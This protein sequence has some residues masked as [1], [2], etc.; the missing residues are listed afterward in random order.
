MEYFVGLRSRVAAGASVVPLVLAGLS[1]S[2][3]SLTTAY[4]AG[5]SGGQA[6]YVGTTAP[7][8]SSGSGSAGGIS[9]ATAARDVGHPSSVHEGA[10]TFPSPSGTSVS[11]SPGGATT[12]AGLTHADQRLAGTGPYT[13]TQFSLEPPDQGLCVGNGKVLETIN[14]AFT[15]YSTSGVKLTAT[16]ALNQFFMR[17]PALIRPSLVRGDFIS[18]P[19]CYYDPVGNRW[20]QTVTEVDAPGSILLPLPTH[21][22]IAVSTS[23]DPTGTWN[24]FSITATD[25]GTNG[26]PSHAGCP[27]LADQ[28]LLGAN[29]DGVYISTNE[30]ELTS[31]LFHFNGAQIYALGR[32]SLEAASGGGSVSFAH[33][34]LG[35]V[36]TGD[37]NLPFWGSV[38]PSTSPRPQGGTEL[39]MSASPEDQFQNNALVDNRIAVWS[40]TGTQTLDS[41][42]PSLKVAHR[43]LRTE[44]YGSD[45]VGGFAATQKSGPTPLRDALGDKDA[46]NLLNANDSRMNQ[47][48][49]ANGKLYGGVNTVVTA[50]GQPNRVGI[51]YFVVEAGG[52]SEDRGDGA[53]RAQLARQGYLAVNGE[54]VMFPSIGVNAEGQGAMVFSLSGPDFYPSAAYVRFD[55]G[56]AHGPIHITAAGVLPDDG[57]TGYAAFGGNGIARWGDYSAALADRDGSIWMATEWIPGT[58]RTVNANW[59]TSISHLSNG[60]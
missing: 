45:V 13:N 7:A 30:F 57:F 34:N 24:L 42:S 37:P 21:L 8:P 28:P 19:K 51:A 52:G 23:G 35:L 22:L 43:V 27:C 60:D 32:A 6:Q 26:T 44:S 31:H 17:S 58:P 40:L 39:L 53:L 56:G 25:D 48:V 49:L 1:M 50:P 12:F 41:A 4:A 16:T 2:G 14:D 15:V 11:A 55:E 59:G 20:I 54:N 18:D 33:I 36:S 29:R 47:V 5:E 38:Q 3:G 10:L 46:L 9:D